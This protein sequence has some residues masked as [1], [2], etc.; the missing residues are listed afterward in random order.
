MARKPAGA[1][2]AELDAMVMVGVVHLVPPV[3]DLQ[4]QQCNLLFPTGV[5]SR[6]TYVRGAGVSLIRTST[7]NIN[8]KD[9]TQFDNGFFHAPFLGTIHSCE[10]FVMANDSNSMFCWIDGC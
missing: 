6:D 9:D 10:C 8:P 7:P 3:L 4:S 2:A 5:I 1:G